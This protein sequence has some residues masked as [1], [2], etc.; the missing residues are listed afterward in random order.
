[1]EVR[2]LGKRLGDA[3]R[4]RRKG[5]GLTNQILL[6]ASHDMFKPIASLHISL[7]LVRKTG[8]TTIHVLLTF[9]LHLP[10][11]ANVAL[12]PTS[13]NVGASHNC[14]R[15]LLYICKALVVA[16]IWG[17]DRLYLLDCLFQVVKILF[18]GIFNKMPIFNHS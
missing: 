7:C 13:K 16:Q 11:T 10:S 9:Y 2:G 6:T 5:G 14:V 17:K 3:H 12:A 1:M 15:L 18:S 8:K 4:A